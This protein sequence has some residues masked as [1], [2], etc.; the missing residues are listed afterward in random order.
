MVARLPVNGTLNSVH[1]PLD[2]TMGSSDGYQSVDDSQSQGNDPQ[3]VDIDEMLAEAQPRRIFTSLL[4]SPELQQIISELPATT[5]AEV[6]QLFSPEYFIEPNKEIQSHLHPTIAFKNR[7]LPLTILMARFAET[8]RMI[9]ERRRSAG[10]TIGLAEYT[11]LLSC[12]ASMGHGEMADKIWEEMVAHRIEPNVQCYNYLMEAKAWNRCYTAKE[13]HRL[14]ST[15]WIYEKRRW[16]PSN[17]G[18]QGYKTGEDGVRDEVHQLFNSMIENGLNPNEATFLHI[19][20]AASREWD[21]GAVKNTLRT[22]WGVDVDLLDND[23]NDHPQVVVYATSSPLHPS[24]RLLYT[25][26]HIFGSNNDFATALKLVDFISQSYSI[27]VPQYVW[28]ELLQWSFILSLERFGPKAEENM[29]G[30][31]PRDSPLKLFEVCTST[32]YNTPPTFKMHDMITK[33]GWIRQSKNRTF[34]NMHAGRQ[35][36]LTTLRKRNQLFQ[37]LIIMHKKLAFSKERSD[38][39]QHSSADDDIFKS[40]SP[41]DEDYKLPK[42]AF[43]YHLTHLYPSITYPGAYWELYDSLKLLNIRV[44]R[45]ALYIQRWIRLVFSRRKWT[46]TKERWERQELPD[47]IAEWREFLPYRVFYHIKSGAIE[48]EPG[49]FW[50]EGHRWDL[51][52]FVLP[53]WDSEERVLRALM[54]ESEFQELFDNSPATG[55]YQLEEG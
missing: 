2:P 46:G 43:E 23:Q 4:R 19:M 50:P 37:E 28:Q 21:I 42:P 41:H 8:L 38:S 18:Y 15:R 5:F 52:S 25:V 32:P 48:F 27:P 11:H 12:Y 35:L 10:F 3:Q 26:A 9:V 16:W 13:N 31:I 6:L 49:S 7:V 45:E 30:K 44:A 51:A 47:F 54:T 53:L 39:L 17:P 14:R 24:P 36:F 55:D 22:V 33:V 40:F 1:F 29:I 34:Q 20:T